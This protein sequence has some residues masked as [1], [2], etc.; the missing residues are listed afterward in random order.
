MVRALPRPSTP[1]PVSPSSLCHSHCCSSLA[2]QHAV[3][4]VLLGLCTCCAC[5]ELSHHP[6]PAS[7][8]F[9]PLTDLNCCLF[10]YVFIPQLSTDMSLPPA[11]FLTLDGTDTPRETALPTRAHVAIGCIAYLCAPLRRKRCVEMDST[12]S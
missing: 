4:P 8:S 5:L 7:L 3:L 10:L 1:T 12:A 9:L 6:A 2:P 11:A